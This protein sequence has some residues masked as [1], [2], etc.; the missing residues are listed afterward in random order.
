MNFLTTKMEFYN[1]YPANQTQDFTSG[2]SQ[3]PNGDFHEQFANQT[4]SFAGLTLSQE[5]LHDR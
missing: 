4:R 2:Q 5:I 3:E 1:G